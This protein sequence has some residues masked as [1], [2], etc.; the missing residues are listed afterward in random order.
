MLTILSLLC[1]LYFYVPHYIKALDS[2]VQLIN[3][4]CFIYEKFCF[5]YILHMFYAFSFTFF[6]FIFRSHLH[7]VIFD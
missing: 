6:L 7:R 3:I 2:F 4:L 1:L 5:C